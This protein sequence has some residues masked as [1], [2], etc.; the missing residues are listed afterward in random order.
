MNQMGNGIIE[1]RAKHTVQDLEQHYADEL[2]P[3][4]EMKK[5]N[6]SFDDY[7]VLLGLIG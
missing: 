2:I 5:E 1:M 4:L 7:L 6:S 3:L